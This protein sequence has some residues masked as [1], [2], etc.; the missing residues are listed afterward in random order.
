MTIEIADG[1][2]RTNITNALMCAITYT[3]S[4]LRSGV[5]SSHPERRSTDWWDN[6]AHDVGVAKTLSVLLDKIEKCDA[7]PSKEGGAA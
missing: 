6:F 7:K 1:E 5:E 4:R 2:E 3:N